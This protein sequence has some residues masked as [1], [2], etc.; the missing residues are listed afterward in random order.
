MFNMEFSFVPEVDGCIHEENPHRFMNNKFL[1]P[2]SPQEIEDTIAFIK[3]KFSKR[4][5]SQFTV[6]ECMNQ[7]AQPLSYES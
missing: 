4:R 2:V 1:C 6:K 3:I 7:L 5:D